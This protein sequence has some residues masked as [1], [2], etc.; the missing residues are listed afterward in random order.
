M[1]GL[2]LITGLVSGPGAML[3]HAGL[4]RLTTT[5]GT[6]PSQILHTHLLILCLVMLGCDAGMHVDNHFG[7]LTVRETLEFSARCQSTGYHRGGGVSCPGLA[8]LCMQLV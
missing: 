8:G 5:R 6:Y 2:A 1:G 4:C 7:E 3:G